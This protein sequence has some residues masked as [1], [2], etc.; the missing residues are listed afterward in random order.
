MCE[1]GVNMNLWVGYCKQ[2]L[3]DVW[4]WNGPSLAWSQKLVVQHFQHWGLKSIQWHCNI[5]TYL[6]VIDSNDVFFQIFSET[7]CSPTLTDLRGGGGCSRQPPPSSL[8]VQIL[9]V[10][11]FVGAPTLGKSWMR[12]SRWSFLEKKIM[13][14]D[15]PGW[16]GEGRSTSSIEYVVWAYPTSITSVDQSVL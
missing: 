4:W 11:S 8:S 6:S 15:L 14:L 9:N 1:W 16:D 12:H 10:K 5:H 2:I 3:I 7:F 13:P